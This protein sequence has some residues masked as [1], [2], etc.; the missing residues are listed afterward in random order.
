MTNDTNDTTLSVFLHYQKVRVKV[1]NHPFT[2]NFLYY[3]CVHLYLFPTAPAVKTIEL[4][5]NRN[6]SKRE[7][8]LQSVSN[9][10]KSFWPK[11]HLSI[12]TIVKVKCFTLYQSVPLAKARKWWRVGNSFSL[13]VMQWYLLR[14]DEKMNKNQRFCSVYAD[15]IC[16]IWIFF[17]NA[18]ELCLCIKMQTKARER[19]VKIYNHKIASFKKEY[20]VNKTYKMQ[21]IKM[22]FIFTE[23]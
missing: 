19:N 23:L 9:W 16:E 17:H 13:S 10:L 8:K 5:A 18:K 6:I 7:Y 15:F 21:K 1:C 12:L 2:L 4:F 11:W 3:I 20:V 22:F 14:R